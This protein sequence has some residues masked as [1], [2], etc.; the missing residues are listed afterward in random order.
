MHQYRALVKVTMTF[1]VSVEGE[2]NSNFRSGRDV[3]EGHAFD[4][5]W[6]CCPKAFID[7]DIDC[8]CIKYEGFGEERQDEDDDR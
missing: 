3:A 6:D 5:V 4:K 1:T 8:E 2:F 7:P